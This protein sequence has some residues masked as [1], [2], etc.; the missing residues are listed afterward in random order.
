MSSGHVMI[1]GASGVIG[2]AAVDLFGR[3]EDWSVTALS[4]RAPM[5]GA[6]ARHRHIA[7]DLTNAAA[8]AAAVADLPPV[9]HLVYAAV[10]EAPGLVTGWRDAELI[11]ENGRM[12]EH[13]L[14][15]LSAR[16]QLRHVVMLQGTKAYGGHYHPISI[17]AKEDR[18]RDAHPN[19]YWLHED[20]A[21]LRASQKGFAVTI[22]RPQ[23]L[24]GDAPGVAMN[25]VLAIGAY[26][27]LCHAL[28][29]PFAY[30]GAPTALWEMTD[31][32]L[33]A[34]AFAWAFGSPA[35][36]GEIFN[37]TN[38]DVLVPAHAWSEVAAALG[39]PDTDPVELRLCDFFARPESEAAWARLARD[40]DLAIDSLPALLGQSHHYADLLLGPRLAGKSVPM[41]VSTIKLRQA[42]FSDCR[43][44]VDSLLSALE[45]MVALNLLPA[46]P[47]RT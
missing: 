31:A 21:R 5:V 38:G 3:S 14:D 43:D 29:C 46:I 26:A 32:P 22:F 28:G 9:T 19:F 47:G 11:A 10:K 42:G 35:A 4:R 8:C 44:S 17:P 20:H 36:V 15:P 16:D 34:R 40:H 12:F 24:L 2:A 7:V 41:L 6:A 23:V 1:V 37:I 30:P 45:R 27:A 39:H 25:P 33:L 18:P 13:I